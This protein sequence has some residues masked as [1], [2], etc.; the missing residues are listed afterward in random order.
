[1]N[2]LV[3]QF[4]GLSPLA[5][6]VVVVLAVAVWLVSARSLPHWLM[7]MRSGLLVLLL[8]ALAGPTWLWLQRLPIPPR[9]LVLLDTSG[10]MGIDGQDLEATRQLD[11]LE[12]LGTTIPERDLSA[13][14]VA[15]QLRRLLGLLLPQRQLI[16]QAA[17]A[18]VAK[19]LQDLAEHSFATDLRRETERALAHIDAVNADDNTVWRARHRAWQSHTVQTLDELDR[20]QNR[21]DAALVNSLPPDAPLLQAVTELAH[22]SR[23][24][25]ARQVLQT[26][27]AERLPPDVAVHWRRFRSDLT[28]LP[29]SPPDTGGATDPM[30]S[31]H[32]LHADPELGRWD[33]VLLVSDGR[34]TVPGDP[35]P[36]ARALRARGLQ[37]DLVQVGQPGPLADAAV[38]A[39]LLPA[40]VH[41]GGRV[42]ARVRFRIPRSLSTMNWQMHLTIDGRLVATRGCI[43]SDDWQD[44]HIPVIFDQLG[45]RTVEARLISR[46]GDQPASDD[47]CPANDKRLAAVIVHNRP[48]R[49]LLCDRLPRWE[50]RHLYQLC[51]AEPQMQAEVRYLLPGRGRVQLTPADL[52]GLD[53]L[54]LGDLSS[55]QLGEASLRAL[56]QLVARGGA[57]IALAGPNAMPVGL[58]MGRLAEL[59][60]ARAGEPPLRVEQGEVASGDLPWIAPLGT[61]QLG[62]QVL[63]RAQDGRPLV[64]SHR[65]GSGRVLLVTSDQLWRWRENDAGNQYRDFWL[66]LLRSA[67]TVPLRGQN[68]GLSMAVDRAEIHQGE[69][70]MVRII[71]PEQP[72]LRVQGAGDRS[73][74][75]VPVQADPEQAG[76]WLARTRVQEVG[77]HRILVDTPSGLHEQ[78]RVLVRGPE[79][80][81]LVNC[82]TDTEALAALAADLDARLVPLPEVDQLLSALAQNLHGRE[83]R[84]IERLGP[85]EGLWFLLLVLILLLGEWWWRQRQGWP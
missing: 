41:R 31:L 85:W 69:N 7:A 84:R 24:E 45:T 21:A 23:A 73:P 27:L 40:H 76:H 59:L 14:Q 16:D 60:P 2:E 36:Y 54:V 74:L 55:R 38:A 65:V 32:A 80:E 81:E 47:R 43:S 49:V 68:P 83:E 58:G 28:P 3:W 11:L 10:S 8:A 72:R 71:S 35:S 5:L 4:E 34:Q 18:E 37:V 79:D 46:K 53:V 67:E 66:N 19:R 52:D 77:S 56:D 39:V 63:L 30:S 1:M 9:L 42:T 78:R 13:R 51:Q 62:A 64:V 75:Q 25:R 44:L 48:L 20:A 57:L 17:L 22:W 12:R 82:S 29:T 33:Q 26:Q 6:G 15:V 50:M 70:L 61:L